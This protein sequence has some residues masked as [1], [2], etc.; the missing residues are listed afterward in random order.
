LDFC[1]ELDSLLH[2]DLP[3]DEWLDAVAALEPNNSEPRQTNHST[4]S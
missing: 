2:S 1:A 4:G 3:A